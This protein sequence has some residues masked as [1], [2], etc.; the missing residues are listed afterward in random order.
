MVLKNCY[1]KTKKKIWPSLL[2]TFFY[3]EWITIPALEMSIT[4]F[5]HIFYHYLH[6]VEPCKYYLPKLNWQQEI[7]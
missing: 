3:L 6:I 7:Q 4:Y 2:P 1:V 5:K